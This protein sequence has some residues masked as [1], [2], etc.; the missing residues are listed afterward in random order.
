MKLIANAV[1]TTS[2]FYDKAR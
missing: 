2:L 1:V